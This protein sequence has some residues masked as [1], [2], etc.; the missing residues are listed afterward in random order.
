MIPWRQFQN[1]RGSLSKKRLR[2]TV[3]W[4]KNH[5]F[6]RSSFSKLN[7]H[8]QSRSTTFSKNNFSFFE[9]TC[10]QFRQHSTCSFYI[11][12]LRAQLFCAYSIGLYFTGISLPAQ[13]LRVEHWWNLAL[14]SISPTH[15]C[16]MQMCQCIEL[17]AKDA[18][19]N[20]QQ[21]FTQLYQCK[22]MVKLG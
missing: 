21:N 2:T 14:G 12:K 10:D 16:K 8:S 17:R 4:I 5:F 11:R 3:L 15:L 22:E 1:F 7:F 6:V 13:K 19:L 9:E 18:I 20:H